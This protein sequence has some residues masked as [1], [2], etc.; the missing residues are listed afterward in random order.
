MTKL[1]IGLLG[2]GV[3]AT[4]GYAAATGLETD[5]ART[6]SLPGATSTGE[7]TTSSTS[8]AGTTTDDVNDISG[9]CDEAEHRNDPRCTGVSTPVPAPARGVTTGDDDGPG[10]ISGPCDEAEHRNDPR[11]TGGAAA[12]D[13]G[14]DDDNS[15][16]GSRDDGDDDRSGHGGDDDD[17]DRSGSNSG[18]G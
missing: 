6:V 8:T 16:R 2:A 5:P 11:C 18:K 12:D 10:D 13:R 1:L 3:I 14:G 7:T 4:A 9:P 17:G 15:G